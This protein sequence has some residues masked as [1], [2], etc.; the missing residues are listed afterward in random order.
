MWLF[1]VYPDKREQTQNTPSGWTTISKC[2]F[3]LKFV[4]IHKVQLIGVN[5]ISPLFLKI[6]KHLEKQ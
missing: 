4:H 1:N 6:S 3:L 2:L 5:F